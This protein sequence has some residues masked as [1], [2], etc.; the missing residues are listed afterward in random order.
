MEKRL[1]ALASAGSHT[2]EQADGMLAAIIQR[3]ENCDGTGA[4]F[5][6][7]NPGRGQGREMSLGKGNGQGASHAV[8]PAD[9]LQTGISYASVLLWFAIVTGALEF[10]IQKV[11]RHQI[12]PHLGS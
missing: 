5:C 8:S 2:Q 11:K 4:G 1:E 10:G 6:G 3:Q 9:V 7:G 12:R